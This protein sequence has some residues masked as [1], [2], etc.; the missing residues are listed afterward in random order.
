MKFAVPDYI[1]GSRIEYSWMLEG[2]D[3]E[4]S[5]FGSS[6]EAF[7]RDLPVGNYR[8]KIRYRKDIFDTD[9]KSLVIPVRVLPLWYQTFGARMAFVALVVATA[10]AAVVLFRRAGRRRH[11]L[12]RLRRYEHAGKLAPQTAAAVRDRESVAGLTAVYRICESLRSENLTADRQS[13]AV[14][15]VREI[16]V[17]LLWPYGLFGRSENR[18]IPQTCILPLRGASPLRRS[19]TRRLRCWPTAASI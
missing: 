8:F 6:S 9:F 12:G 4:W 3:K 14:D 19:P 10:S 11:L 13:R 2:H 7:Y 17:S 16:V 5:R 1:S 18:K 15:R